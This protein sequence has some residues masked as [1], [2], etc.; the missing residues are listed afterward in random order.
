MSGDYVR[1]P[2]GAAKSSGSRISWLFSRRNKGRLP[3]AVVLFLATLLSILGTRHYIRCRRAR[4][5]LAR[6]NERT[7][8]LRSYL[9]DPRT[10]QRDNILSSRLVDQLEGPPSGRI[11]ETALNMRI[12]KRL[13]SLPPITEFDHQIKDL[14]YQ[15]LFPWLTNSSLTNNMSQQRGAVIATGAHYF[16]MCVHAIR[17][18]RLLNFT[19]PIEVFYL[20]ADDLPAE[21][22]AFLNGMPG[23]R[24]IDISSRFNMTILELRSW[25]IKPFAILGS[26]FKEVLLL[27]ADVV[28]VKHPDCLFESEEYARTG[29]VFFT[30]RFLLNRRRHYRAWFEEIMPEPHSPKLVNSEMY[31]DLSS[32]QQESGV[33]LIDKTRRLT[34]LLATCLLNCKEERKQIHRKT[35]GEKETFWLGFEISEDPYEFYDNHAGSV[36]TAGIHRQTGNI[37]HCGKLAH[38]DHDGELLWFNDSIIQDKKRLDSGVATLLHIGSK[39]GWWNLCL[40]PT[41]LRML[42]SHQQALLEKIKALWEPNPAKPNT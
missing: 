9:D 41:D 18:L 13:L 26:S 35:Y 20:N 42:P 27:D 37:L 3:Y 19:L 34:G 10:F 25:D 33:V 11:L 6:H 5:D 4:A 12:F 8:V 39:G 40:K 17:T 14:V 15:R 2:E 22:V 16:P 29:A 36:G 23:V 38:F 1:V 32:Y 31:R 28:L 24:A 21:S 7:E 30:D